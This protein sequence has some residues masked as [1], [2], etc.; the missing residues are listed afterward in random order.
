[1]EGISSQQQQRGAA[2]TVHGYEVTRFLGSG[3]FS[4]VFA[5]THIAT[6]RQVALKVTSKAEGDIEA[7]QNEAAALKLVG[8]HP[9]IVSIYDFFEDDEYLYLVLQHCPNGSLHE[10]LLENGPVSERQAGKW[11][12]QL[13]G[14]VKHCHSRGVVSR[15]FKNANVLINARGD[16][17]LCDFGLA[18]IVSDTAT[19]RLCEASGSAVFSAPEVY[20][21]K[22][23][24]YLGGP[25]EVWSLG[26]VLHSMLARTLPFPV[27]SYRKSWHAYEPP[28][29]I[30]P[31][32]RELLLAIF[33]LD[34]TKRPTLDTLVNSAWVQRVC[35][36]TTP[37]RPA[38]S[39]AVTMARR[40]S[41]E[42]MHSSTMRRNS[43]VFAV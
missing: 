21:A 33:Q 22:T 38:T 29:M 24:H 14:A 17:V 36:A 35:G 43:A 34:P 3:C 25:A 31:R 9:H 27:K 5:A 18:A 6:G 20:E 7:V 40:A 39:A 2:R 10:Y 11:F 12:T 42:A 37:Q 16:V 41:V 32:A 1:M 30:S 23:K 28:V 26:A 4:Q 13:V 15:D 19:D 8:S